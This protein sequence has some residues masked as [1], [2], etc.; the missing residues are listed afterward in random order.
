MNQRIVDTRRSNLK[1]TE[2]TLMDEPEL[3]DKNIYKGLDE[4]IDR[5]EAVS[6]IRGLF[7]IH[8]LRK[9]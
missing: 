1:S 2:D 4:R 6:T 3:I 7:F 9:T 5:M 8:D